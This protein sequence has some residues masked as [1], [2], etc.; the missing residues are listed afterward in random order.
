MK[1]FRFNIGNLSHPS[2]N[3]WG[4][5]L[6]WYN[7]WYT[8]K[9]YSFWLHQDK[10]FTTFFYTYVNYGLLYP[11]SFLTHK[12]WQNTTDEIN[13]KI[14]NNNTPQTYQ[15]RHNSKYFRAARYR[16]PL[17]KV[18]EFY[19]ARAVVS[20]T[21]VSKVWLLRYGNWFILNFY[22]FRPREIS[23]VQKIKF[24]SSK[25][26]TPT[27]LS[28]ENRESFRVLKRI[29]FIL[30]YYQIQQITQNVFYKF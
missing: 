21:Y 27:T 3:K 11:A 7:L 5:N 10:L 26:K 4:I 14:N 12:Y 8:D 23:L 2:I 18:Y 24:A 22:C 25:R 1:H 30:T 15:Q 20:H 9:N 19:T 29:K 13:K 17:T 28:F 6:F 16:D